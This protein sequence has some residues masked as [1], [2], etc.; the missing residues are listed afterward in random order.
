MTRRRRILLFVAVS[1][2]L[3]VVTAWAV[4]HSGPVQSEMAD[5]ITTAIEEKTGWRVEIDE[6][7]LR[8][9]PARLVVIGVVASASDRPAVT[10]ERLEATWRWR[11]VVVAPHR[12][13][14]VE[15]AGL[16]LDLRDFELPYAL[17][18]PPDADPVDPWRVVEVDRFQVVDSRLVG[19]AMDVSATLEGLRF[20]GSLSDARAAAELD[21]GRLLLRRQ[22]RELALGPLNLEV[23]ASPAGVMIERLDIAGDSL[24]VVL[25]AEIGL[26]PAIT[27]RA[28]FES[29]AV[30]ASVLGWWDPNLASGLSPEGVLE[31]DGWVAFDPEDGLSARGV[32]GGDS[33]RVAGY[34][35]AELE[36][37][38]EDGAPELALAGPEW[39]RAT[40]TVVGEGVASM[41]ARLLEAP[42]E[43][44]LAFVAPQVSEAVPGPVRL[45][46]S[47][48]GTVG[49]PVTLESLS[50]SVD[51]SAETSRGRASVVAEGAAETWTVHRMGAETDALSF[52]GFGRFG[53]GGRVAVTADLRVDDI[54]GAL[55]LVEPWITVPSGLSPG[56][57]PVTVTAAIA[58]TVD[59]PRI[60]L[61]GQWSAP[62]LAGWALDLVAV[63]AGGG[64]DGVDWGVEARR[65]DG[66]E[67]TA[68]G[69]FD[70]ASWVADGTWRLRIGR[71][72]D[73]LKL[74]SPSSAAAAQIVGEVRGEGRFTWSADGWSVDGAATGREIE[75]SGWRLDRVDVEFDATQDGL[76]IGELSAGFLGGTVRGSGGIGSGG[77]SA[78]VS[79]DL[80]WSGLEI[81]RLP[82][83]LPGGADGTIDGRLTADGTA[84]RPTTEFELRWAPKDPGSP[85]PAL[86][87]AGSLDGGELTVITREVATDAGSAIVRA[88]VPLGGLPLP[89]WLWPDAPDGPVRLA[90]DGHD[91]RSEPLVALFGIE[92]LP[93]SA[94]GELTLDAAWDPRHRDRTRIFAELSDLRVRHPGGGIEA[95]N[96]VELRMDG[97]RLRL[98]PVVLTGPQTRIEVSGEGDLSSGRLDGRLEA[99]VAPTIARLI[100]YPIQ[101]YQPIHMSAVASGSFHAPRASITI[102]HPGG[103]LVLRDPP[104]QIRDLVLSAEVVEG[105]LW[106]NDGRAEVN[107]GRVE[108]G[109]GWDTESGQGLVAEVDNVVVFLEGILSQWSGTLAIEP[110]PDR[111]ARVT[112]ELNLVAGLWDQEVSL[113]GALF[114]PQS[115]D[116]SGDDP[117]FDVLLDLD[118]RGRGIVRVENNLGRFDARW[119]VLRVSGSAA[120]PEI[121]GKINIAPGGRISLAGQRVDVRRGSLVFTGD[122]MIDPIVEIVPESDIA[123]FGAGG[124]RVDTAAL[125]TQGLVGGIAGA[126]G[127]EN[128]TLQPAEISVEVERDSSEQLMLGQRISHN[129]AVFFASNTRDVQDRTSMLQLWNL[130]GLKGL[131]IQGFQKTL[132][133]EAGGNLIQRFQWGGS[134]LYEDRPTIRK[135][136]LDGDWPIGKRRLRKATGFRRGQPYDP[137][138]TFVARVRME[139]E[140]AGAGFQEATVAATAVESNN[141][142]TMRFECDPG[143]RQ[144]VLFEG[145]V[146]PRRIREE[147]T[148]LYQPP[149]LERLGFRNMASQLDRY[150]DAEGFPDTEVVVERRGETVIAEVRRGDLVELAGPVVIG[151]PP[152]VNHAIRVRLGSPA[153][154]AL[155]R[156]DE[157]RAKRVAGRVLVDLGYP[158]AFIH[159]V[160]EVDLDEGRSEV[161]IEA[162]LGP[163]A[164]IDELVVKGDDPLGLTRADDFSLREGSPLNRGTLDLAASQLRAGY[165]AAGYSDAGV[166]GSMTEI[167]DGRWRVTI[168]ILPGGLRKVREVEIVGLDHTSRKALRSGITV[169]EGEILRNPDLD[170]TAVRIANFAPIERV[171]VR[172]SPE[173]TDGAKVVLEVYE[174]PRWTTE[175]GGGWSTERGAQVRFGLRDD[176]LIGRGLSLNLRGRWDSTEWL[177]FVVASLPPPPGRRLS[178]TSTVGF[179]RGEAPQ[180]PDLLDQDEASWSIE[181]TRWL[182]RGDL[183]AGTVGE[184]ITAYYRFT[185]TRTYGLDDS[186]F[187]P[188]EVDTTIDTGL[189][190]ARY[191]RDR[192]DSPFDPTS[193]YGVIIDAGT[194]RE[195]LGSDFDYWTALGTGSMARR[196]PWSS[197]WI[198]SL[199]VGVAEPL[200]GQVLE[201]NARFFAGGQGSIRGFDRNSVGPTDFGFDGPV[202]A[203]G[204]AL[205]VLNEE[206]R[207]PIKGGFRAALFADIGQVWESW[208]VADWELAVGAGVGIRWATPIGPVWADVAWP[209]ANRGISSAKP[210]FY[211]GIGRPF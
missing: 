106:V 103:A 206:L 177:G 4:L 184:Q 50:G 201:D 82:V 102:E 150:F 54:D 23:T 205:F 170:T 114:G 199:R 198:Q 108:L 76:R 79:L 200:H 44:L 208:G 132:T 43:R 143:P 13:R 47:V 210:K 136:K 137:F 27:G 69:S 105:R 86:E 193:G 161:R 116:P 99:V 48:D 139:R 164:V 113:G 188:I 1:A 73:V 101:I 166:T 142:W 121:R 119:D 97:S 10:F 35:L 11:E 167:E 53:P 185:R 6:T 72:D 87:A 8:L 39:G 33:I 154:L 123:V 168:R 189:V 160:T 180:N 151:A 18:S 20:A 7:R 186:G 80:D 28:S 153:E 125:A 31:L 175:V 196:A 95:E 135:L 122:P 181:A 29:K 84:A 67:A 16:S 148:A 178:F 155:L 165:D 45:S 61:T 63:R 49:F 37:G 176:N 204:G 203:G 183:A 146:P 138:L 65:G 91:L 145:K 120:A 90:A 40:V 96:P 98:E 157:A 107:E 68:V 211:F 110:E 30:V 57:G 111:L 55:G 156:A 59:D 3:F 70:P 152:D 74:V 81:G 56:G 129:I 2:V 36:F 92:P 209:V 64:L 159:S 21:A 94:T 19:R 66:A 17:E 93:F 83:G 41:S 15:L 85:V 197:T 133:D 195:L 158:D 78:P 24:A 89:D 112:G 100:P 60:E 169:E 172:T 9:W 26:D 149:P 187:I 58:G 202:P 52:A 104:L 163:R 12:L 173:G 88:T 179:L 109:G 171:D 14:S 51:L 174:K 207:I 126:L 134:S 34:E 62:E 144:Q 128:E 77:L 75:A 117:L 141:A 131:A 118:V 38:F 147:V 124:D 140:L 5:R 162:D 32:H 182:G 71:L 190:G 192:F 42:V 25:G 130:P 115:L 22:E 127:F 194:S 191:V 46:G